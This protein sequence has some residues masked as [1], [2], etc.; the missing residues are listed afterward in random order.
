MCSLELKQYVDSFRVKQN[1]LILI[2]RRKINRR[3]PILLKEFYKTE[4]VQENRAN[5]LSYSFLTPLDEYKVYGIRHVSCSTHNQLGLN[6]WGWSTSLQANS[7]HLIGLVKRFRN[8]W[9]S[10]YKAKNT[11]GI[12]ST[13]FEGSN[14]RKKLKSQSHI[15]RY[16]VRFSLVD[17][18]WF[19]LLFSLLNFLQEEGK[20][21]NLSGQCW[22]KIL[23]ILQ[24]QWPRTF[25]K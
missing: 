11:V 5:L 16:T 6:Q 14:K 19:N 23:I 22:N 8:V 25:I 18:E 1:S 13:E 20:L 4:R 21:R 3:L 10:I 15:R 24:L 7:N 12:L 2:V 9:W 17:D